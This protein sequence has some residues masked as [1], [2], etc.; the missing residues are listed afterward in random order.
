MIKYGYT[1]EIMREFTYGLR[2][3]L[4]IALGYLAVSFSFGVLTTSLGM[5]P[6]FATI[7]SLTNI[8]SA[9]Q[10]AGVKLM[11]ETAGYIEIGLTVL[12]INLRYSLMSLS[13]SQKIDETIPTGIRLLIGYGITDEIYAV[14]IMEHKKVTAKYMFGL[15][16][17]PILF[18]TLGTLLGALFSEIMPEKLLDA[19][20]IA[21]YAMFIAIF[22]PDAMKNK[23]IAVVILIACALTCIMTYV[24]YVNKI[25]L[26]FK[27][28]IA[29]IISSIIGAILFPIDTEE[30][31]EIKPIIKENEENESKEEASYDL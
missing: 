20:G 17:L 18:W 16:L 11:A 13:L 24:P 8:T 21:L 3:G 30:K 15:M 26:G 28:I 5:T 6:L 10:Y 1:G 19:M 23:K 25:G 2:K 7:I 29:T 22:I 14:A 9:G 12:L 4:P 31:K 27:T